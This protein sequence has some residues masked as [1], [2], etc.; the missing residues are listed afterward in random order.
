[1]SDLKNIL[2]ALLCTMSDNRSL[3]V[4]RLIKSVYLFDWTSVL[5]FRSEHARLDW[6][7]GMCGPTCDEVLQTINANPS[8]FRL[9]EKD[10]HI[11]GR[12]TVVVCLSE[13]N[14]SGLSEMEW[15]AVEHV[16]SATRGLPWDELVQLISSTMPVVI[17][18]YGSPLDLVRAASLRNRALGRT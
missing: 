18:H 3:S 14:R 5:N 12:K 2:I 1:M 6:S 4:P 15:K 10:N 17:S 7:C 13:M 16:S 11:G 8:V 9:E